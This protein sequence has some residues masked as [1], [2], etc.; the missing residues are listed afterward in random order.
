MIKN[1]CL[2]YEDAHCTR[3][4]PHASKFS[5]SRTFL[6][7]G[8]SERGFTI[9]EIL[10]V[11]AIMGIIATLSVTTF[12]NMHDAAALRAGGNEIYA[13][14]SSA[15]TKTLASKD[16]TVYGVHV[17][18]TTVTRFRGVSYVAG[19]A[20]NEV[21]AFEAGVTATS[22]LIA[23]GGDILFARLTGTPSVFGTIYVRDMAGAGTTTIIIHGTGLVEYE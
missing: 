21:Y 7:K 10:V 13:A 18:S 23:G 16:E 17:S 8:F 15:Q 22:T 1:I 5:Q 6:N 4:T 20:A 3:C 11:L 9:S 19:D 14:L 12:R 2:R